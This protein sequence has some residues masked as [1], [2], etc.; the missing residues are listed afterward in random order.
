MGMTAATFYCQ[1]QVVFPYSPLHKITIGEGKKI[2]IVFQGNEQLE[3]Y[4]LGYT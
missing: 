2:D 1:K 3:L 4:F